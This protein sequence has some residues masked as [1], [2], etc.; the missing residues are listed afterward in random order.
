[1]STAIHHKSIPVIDVTNA[2]RTI[3]IE[4]RHEHYLGDFHENFDH[5][6]NLV[7]PFNDLVDYSSPRWHWVKDS[8]INPF[9]FRGFPEN[10]A[11]TRQYIEL[12]GLNKH[13]CP[14]KEV[15]DLG[16]F[17]GMSAI[18]FSKTKAQP[19]VICVEPDPAN[20][21]VIDINLCHSDRFIVV[22]P[23]AVWR[24]CKGIEFSSEGNQGSAATSIVG[25]NRG[26]V[27]QVHTTT[28]SDLA[29]RTWTP[30][31][32]PGSLFIKCDIEGAEA[33]I[34][35]NEEAF[36]RKFRPLIVIEPHH[37]NG[38]P[39]IEL[40]RPHLEKAGYTLEVIDQPDCYLPLVLAKPSIS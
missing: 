18:M 12:A 13:G 5:Y 21:Q 24:D 17:S 33:V 28:L 36:L 27:V 23:G 9:F 34:F 22:V 14:I 16:G 29:D 31:T 8:N 32:Q 20:L 26:T 40:F 30:T 7:T 37:V 19:F 2:G 1:M 10:A 6:Y 35:E 11:T 3:R 25:G 15:W 38:V 4:K 39:N